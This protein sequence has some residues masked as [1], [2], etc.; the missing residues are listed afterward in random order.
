MLRRHRSS[1]ASVLA[2]VVLA[3][4]AAA[5]PV[6][7]EL[8]YVNG[9]AIELRRLGV[10]GEPRSAALR[11]AERWRRR[12]PESAVMLVEAGGGVVVGRQRGPIHE[13]ALFKRGVSPQHSQV[14]VAVTHLGLG[15]RTLPS[16]PFALPRGSR[17][18]SVVEA[19]VG[20]GTSAEFVVVVEQTAGLAYAAVRSAAI[21]ANWTVQAAE[22]VRAVRSAESLVVVVQPMR[23]GVS[24]VIQHRR[25]AGS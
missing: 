24:L 1:W 13:T 2:V 6:R 14:T 8:A 18:L 19:A 15:T 17:L 11:L 21:T 7:A 25:N 3:A 10:R 5:A 4:L 22:P 9:I 20:S 12:E 23:R 16:P